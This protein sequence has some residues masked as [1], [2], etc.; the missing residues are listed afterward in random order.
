MTD[1]LSFFAGQRALARIKNHGL[2]PEQVSVVAGA[3]G[4]PKWLI[5]GSI[6]RFLFGTWFSG[7]KEPLF[8]VGSSAGAW[9]LAAA[10]RKDSARAIT[11]LRHAYIHQRYGR[12][13]GHGD[14]TRE[15]IAIFNRFLET[16]GPDEILSHPAFRLTVLAVRSRHLLKSDHPMILGTGLAAAAALNLST[17]RSLGL[18]FERALFSDPRTDPPF[19]GMG[20]F[21]KVRVPLRQGN[22]APALLASGSIP[23]VMAG[24]EGIDGAPEGVYRDGG[25]L[26][27]HLDIPFNG[28]RGQGIVLFP[29]YTDRIVPG[30]LDKKLWY[31]RPDADRIK[32]VL[33][34]A[35][36]RR[37][38]RLLPD[39]RI[40]DRND[41]FRFAGRNQDR[42]EQ[43]KRAAELSGL[44]ADDLAQ[45]LSSGRL[46]DR[47]QPFAP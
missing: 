32:D 22:L 28:S 38:T 36:N 20:G 3:A 6:D 5:L 42:I 4:G 39:G 9:R 33:L 44:L 37:F 35:P 18:F 17:R 24:V 10:C 31:R 29:H 16:A 12:K 41:F 8:L 26:D 40:P 21:P 43:W 45:A 34:I 46:V 30:W 7:R 27:Y 19:S 14:I 25:T 2:S 13:V 11:R 1:Y 23:L 15:C 47:L